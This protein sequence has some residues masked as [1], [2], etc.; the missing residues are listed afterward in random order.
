M[1]VY[2][3]GSCSACRFSQYGQTKSFFCLLWVPESDLD[4]CKEYAR[5]PLLGIPAPPCWH[6]I[7]FYFI[8]NP[9]KPR[10]CDLACNF[11][12]YL[13]ISESL[14]ETPNHPAK[15]KI[16]TKGFDAHH[17]NG[18]VGALRGIPQTKRKKMKETG[19]CIVTR[20]TREKVLACLSSLF[21]Q[22]PDPATVD[23]VVVDN[24]SLDNPVNEI[25]ATFPT[26]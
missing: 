11:R 4:I 15:S 6:D 21:E 17:I 7:I 14:S 25:R 16:K 19:V 8:L 1:P 23:I 20:N 18:I 9:T 2:P 3:S 12:F 24:N 13:R 26:V 22:T 5:I 10:E